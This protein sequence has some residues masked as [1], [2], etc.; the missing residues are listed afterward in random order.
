VTT[1][2]TTADTTPFDTTSVPPANS[3]AAVPWLETAFNGID[4]FLTTQGQ[5]LGSYATTLST[6]TLG[7]DFW[8]EKFG[9][10]LTGSDAAPANFVG[11]F[12]G[13]YAI[14][15]DIN[16]IVDQIQAGQ[17][18]EGTSQKLAKDVGA[19]VGQITGAAL[20]TFIGAALGI[21]FAEVTGGT[22]V[23][24]GA[25]LGTTIGNQFGSVV[26]SYLGG[27][28]FS[29]LELSAEWQAVG[30]IASAAGTNTALVQSGEKPTQ[31]LYNTLGGHTL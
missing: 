15:T 20:G 11:A 27:V 13:G 5:D 6:I 8:L 16:T 2:P 28:A 1:T 7:V 12:T 29:G 23:A 26:G 10:F 19:E 25:A 18:T 14:G 24:V 17:D 30:A 3:P 21:P 4:N 31:A 22:S 9:P